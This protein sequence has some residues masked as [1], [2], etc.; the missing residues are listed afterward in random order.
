MSHILSILAPFLLDIVYASYFMQ[1][2][3]SYVTQY[4]ILERPHDELVLLFT[5]AI[6]INK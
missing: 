1:I 4:V 3:G 5:T 6:I 2:Y